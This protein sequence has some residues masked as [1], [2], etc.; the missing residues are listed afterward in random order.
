[1]NKIECIGNYYLATKAYYLFLSGNLYKEEEWTKFI[2][3][4]DYICGAKV[5][6]ITN[7]MMSIKE[8]LVDKLEGLVYESKLF[9][10][11]MNKLVEVISL[12]VDDGYKVGE[13]VFKDASTLVAV[14]RNKFAHGDYLIDFSN[15]RIIINYQENELIFDIDKLTIFVMKA[16]VSSMKDKKN[17]SY[18]HDVVLFKIKDMNRKVGF[19]TESEV[20]GII[21]KF[22]LINF[23]IESLDDSDIDKKCIEYLDEF[24]LY[25]SVNPDKAFES[26]FYSSLNKFL[27]DRNCKLTIT[28]KSLKD[29]DMILEIVKFAKDEILVRDEFDYR[30]QIELIGS[31]VQRRLNNKYNFFNP[32]SANI[33]NLIV[34]SAIDEENS[35]DY[36]DLSKYFV[37]KDLGEVKI[38]YDELGMTLISMFNVV[39]M[40]PFDDIYTSS[41]GYKVNRKSEFDFSKLDLSKINPSVIKIDEEPLNASLDRYNALLKRKKELELK[42]N[43]YKINLENVTNNGNSKAMGIIN[44]MISDLGNDM[45]LLDNEINIANGNYLDIKN[46]YDNNPMYF[47]NKAIIE[48]I[49][50]ALAHGNYEFIRDKDNMDTRIVFSD[51]YEGELTFKIEISY[52]DFEDMINSSFKVIME[53]MEDIKSIVIKRIK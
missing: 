30:K 33:K 27:K 29:E 5:S 50:N 34:L 8:E 35:V 38:Q 36:E 40:Y 19:K 41:G 20:R 39:F 45:V 51:I 12:K 7:I 17:N 24:N 47:R 31:E 48:G 42:L 14:I 43:S 28:S 15:N 2:L 1:V 52:E 9:V 22:H 11:S 21:K 25:Y 16:F 37:D 6:F 32:L 4:K 49:R 13:Y 44:K 26:K 10:N 53:D 23:N 3:D 46:D 18:D